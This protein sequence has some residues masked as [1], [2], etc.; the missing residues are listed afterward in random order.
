[1]TL[2]TFPFSLFKI[3]IL[4]NRSFQSIRYVYSIFF[5][6][7]LL[8]NINHSITDKHSVFKTK[9]YNVGITHT[10]VRDNCL[11]CITLQ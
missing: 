3:F 4:K 1:M 5:P 2:L 9:L 11:F 7:V 6:S 10:K 8:K